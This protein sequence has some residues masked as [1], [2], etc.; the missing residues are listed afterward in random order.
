MTVD[1]LF[2]PILQVVMVLMRVGALWMFFPI[3]SQG[4]IPAPVRL[5]G[6]L[7][8]SLALLPLAGPHL[9]PWTL[10]ALPGN[11]EIASFVFR[12]FVI[13]AGMGLSARWMFSAVVAAAQWVGTQMGF[14]SAGLFDPEF[15]QSD[16]SWA[17]FHQWVAITLFLAIGGHWWLIQA[18]ADSYQFDFANWFARLSELQRGS[19]YWAELGTSFFVWMLKLSAPLAVVLLLIQAALGILSKFIPQMNIW[20]VSLPITIA[21]GVFLFSVLS[22][23]Y[24]DALT[25]LF[26][27]TREVSQ[28]WIRFLGTR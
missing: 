14:S 13:G 25:Q 3:F 10:Q 28:T 8:L 4:T 26:G 24:G 20:S 18:I 17:D 19:A 9:P 16:S 1:G 7:T 23:M 21:A 2:L 27:S 22:P 12:E 11:G 15:G 5:A 6:A